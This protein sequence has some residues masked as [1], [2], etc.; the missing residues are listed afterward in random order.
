MQGLSLYC[1]KNNTI[2]Y[3]KKM[4]LGMSITYTYK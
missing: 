1:C 4:L 3:I 2:G